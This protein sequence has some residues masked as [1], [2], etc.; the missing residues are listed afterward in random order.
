VLLTTFLEVLWDFK[1]FTQVWAIRQGG[2]DGASTTLSVLQFVK[3]LSGNNHYGL[4]AAVSVLMIIIIVG[5]T[6]QYLRMLLRSREV[7][8]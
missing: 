5:V 2:P 3:G 4:A 1:V 8:L 6:A 7:D